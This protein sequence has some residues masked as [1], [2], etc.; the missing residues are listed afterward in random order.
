MPLQQKKTFKVLLMYVAALNVCVQTFCILIRAFGVGG[1]GSVFAISV[2]LLVLTS[3]QHLV[4]IIL[5]PTQDSPPCKIPWNSVQQ[6][7]VTSF[8]IKKWMDLK[9]FIHDSNLDGY[10]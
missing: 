4:M 10:K 7:T 3:Y 5:A 6:N 2:S 8:H 9:L 1:E